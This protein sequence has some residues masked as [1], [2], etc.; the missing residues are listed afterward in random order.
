MPGD[1]RHARPRWRRGAFPRRA[2]DLDNGYA[3]YSDQPPGCTPPQNGFCGHFTQV[4][5]KDTQ[6]VGCGKASAA[7]KTVYIVC[8]YYPIGNRAAQKPY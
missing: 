6:V 4:I 3:G 1:E 7:H 2:D 5:W 8:N